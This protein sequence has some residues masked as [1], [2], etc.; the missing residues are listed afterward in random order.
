M[1]NSDRARKL[2]VRTAL[3][4][5]ST[6]A[7]L[8][9][10]QNL[11]MLDNTQFAQNPTTPDTVLELSSEDLASDT[12]INNVAPEL[13]IVRAAPS[14]TI[15]RQSGQERTASLIQPPDPVAV[16]TPQP[17]IV[18]PQPQVSAPQPVIIQS[19]QPARSRSRSTR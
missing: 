2:L 10:A 1:A 11:A 5:S 12:A 16:A 8:V 7:T 19:S 4:T 9:G 13:A 6:I 18:Q 14:I 15:I 3:V 17:V